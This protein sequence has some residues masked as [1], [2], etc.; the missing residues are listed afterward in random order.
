MPISIEGRQDDFELA[1]APDDPP[2]Q[3]SEYLGIEEPAD[4]YGSAGSGAGQ[5]WP[6]RR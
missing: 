4:E 3:A 1:F 6:T 2:A 5:L